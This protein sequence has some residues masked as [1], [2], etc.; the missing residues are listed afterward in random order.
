MEEIREDRIVITSCP[1]SENKEGVFGIAKHMKHINHL[2]DAIIEHAKYL[3]G[4]GIEVFERRDN[5]IATEG[6][7]YMAL[8]ESDLEH[9]E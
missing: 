3:Q 2:I 5:I 6:G 4:E 7:Y 9:A 8:W 1:L